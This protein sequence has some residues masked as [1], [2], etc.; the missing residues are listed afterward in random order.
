MR[1]SLALRRISILAST[2]WEK[3]KGNEK[4]HREVL[5]LL[6]ILSLVLACACSSARTSRRSRRNRPIKLTHWD[7][8]RHRRLEQAECTIANVVEPYN[9]MTGVTVETVLQP[10]FGKPCAAVAG[11]GGYVVDAWPIIRLRNGEV[12]ASSSAER[13]CRTTRLGGHLRPVGIEPRPGRRRAG[14]AYRTSWKH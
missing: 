1:Q 5:F 6:V 11:G 14:A 3:E 12:R 9:E 10:M 8:R 7:R 13:L 4:R 2:V